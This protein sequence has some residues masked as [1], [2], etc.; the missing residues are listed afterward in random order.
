MSEKSVK[1]YP[2]G[3][4]RY[5][6]NILGRAK[7]VRLDRSDVSVRGPDMAGESAGGVPG[8]TSSERRARG[9]SDDE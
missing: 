6:E 8:G 5:R 3:M 1:E 7:V 4:V 9:D 2:Y